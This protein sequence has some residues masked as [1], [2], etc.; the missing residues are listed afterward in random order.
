MKPKTLEDIFKPTKEVIKGGACA[1]ITTHDESGV[2]T[3]YHAKDIYF[4][5]LMGDLERLGKKIIIKN[6]F[7]QDMI[8]R[9]ITFTKNHVIVDI[10]DGSKPL[11][12][13]KD[14]P[15][16]YEPWFMDRGSYLIHVEEIGDFGKLATE[17][18][19]VEIENGE[20]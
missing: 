13:K 16:Y 7:R 15:V 4:C 11:K 19:I 5:G 8:V 2:N 3:V 14:H 6:L 12:F 1:S 18:D 10:M 17:K 20:K 9:T